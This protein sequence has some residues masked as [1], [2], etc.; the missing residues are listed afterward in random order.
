MINDS[1]V[2]LKIQKIKQDLLVLRDGKT[3]SGR[4]VPDSIRHEIISLHKS[5]WSVNR[6]EKEFQIA[7]SA[8]YSWL[9]KTSISNSRQEIESNN[10]QVQSK[11]TLKIKKPKQLKI[12]E[13]VISPRIEPSVFGDLIQ[14]E[15]RSGVKLN[16]PQKH[17]SY[18]FIKSLNSL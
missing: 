9:K 8:I 7:S 15:L 4:R 1:K 2:Q 10:S 17:L 13:D 18:E 3:R 12:V 6:L 11:S 5:R 14:L 16:I